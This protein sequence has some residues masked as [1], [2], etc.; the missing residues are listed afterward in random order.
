MTNR[1]RTAVPLLLLL[2]LAA[3][4]CSSGNETDDAPKGTPSKTMPGPPTSGRGAT[5]TPPKL[6]PAA[7]EVIAGQ[8]GETRGNASFS[9]DAGAQGKALIVAVSCLGMG[10]VKIS[11]PVLGTDFPLECGTAEPAVTYNQLAMTAAHKA[12]TV[13][14]TAPTNTTWAVTVGRGDAAEHE[15]PTTG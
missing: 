5:L 3:G 15:P 13:Q 6:D 8:H 7:G 11:V 10:T 2:T 14:V 12:G 9:Y 4:G 1:L